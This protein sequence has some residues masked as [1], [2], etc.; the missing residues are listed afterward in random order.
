MR[1]LIHYT[2][3]IHRFGPLMKTLPFEVVPTG[4]PDDAIFAVRSL[5]DPNMNAPFTEAKACHFE[6]CSYSSGEYVMLE[7]DARTDGRD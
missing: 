5:V 1:V 3:M 7:P 2:V 6:G 4:L